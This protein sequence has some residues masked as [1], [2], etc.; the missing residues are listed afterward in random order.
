[1]GSSYLG[2]SMMDLL[3]SIGISVYAIDLRGVGFTERDPSGWTCPLQ[4]VED[5]SDVFDYLAAGGIKPPV[6]VGW[7]HGA[8][9]AQLFAQHHPHKISSL[10][11]YGSVF[12]PDD[13]E[14]M[15]SECVSAKLCLLK[16]PLEVLTRPYAGRPKPS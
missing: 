3:V 11:L 10:V 1:M 13:I 7:S 15:T 8:L 2:A 5:I 4:S 9:N 6:F 16:Q 12:N 14:S